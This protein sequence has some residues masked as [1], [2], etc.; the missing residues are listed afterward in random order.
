M[1]NY[2][3]PTNLIMQILKVDPRKPDESVIEKAARILRLGGIV[4]YPTETLYGL[5]ANIMDTLSLERLFEIKGRRKDKPVSIAFRDMEQAERYAVFNQAAKKLAQLMLPG[6]LTMVLP[7]RVNLG[8]MFGGE[9][10]AVRMPSNAVA[11]AILEKTRFPITATSAN[12]SGQADPV[13]A[14]DAINQIGDKVDLVL[15]GGDCEHGKPSTVVDLTGKKPVFL[16]EGAIP[17]SR[18]LG[19]LDKY[20]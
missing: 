2:S 9:K 5:G 3:P 1:I 11:R 15:D 4:V 17:K 10:I 13:C 20:A 16:R 7:A 6:P 19:F 14:K 8:D 18:I 12:L